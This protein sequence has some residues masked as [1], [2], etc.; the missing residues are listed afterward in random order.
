MSELREC[1]ARL[2]D[3]GTKLGTWA[4]QLERAA[5]RD[6]T[7]RRSLRGKLRALLADMETRRNEDTNVTMHVYLSKWIGTL[8]AISGDL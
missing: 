6:D 8:D 2:L 7:A 5:D 1:V 3:A 4:E